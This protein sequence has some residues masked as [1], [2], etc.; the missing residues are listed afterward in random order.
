[1]RSAAHP[2]GDSL[3]QAQLAKLDALIR[4]AG[5]TATDH[6]LEIGCGWGSMAVRAAQTTGCR[7]TGI[8]VSKQQLA[9]ATARVEAAG[10]ADR[11]TLLFCDYRC[12]RWVQYVM[13]CRLIYAMADA[14]WLMLHWQGAQLHTSTAQTTN[15]RLVLFERVCAQEQMLSEYQPVNDSHKAWHPACVQMRRDTPGAGTYD[16]VI[17][18]EMI[19]AVGHEHLAQYFKTINA[20]LKPGGRAAIQVRA[21][22]NAQ[23]SSTG[24]CSYLLTL[25]F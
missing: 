24:R 19:E 2:A 7:W 14:T 8:T 15:Q 17:S 6:V 21:E 25:S 16:K 9:E 3:H 11:V 10:L 5:V 4:T 12:D 13:E 1:M 23:T 22:H 20:M 18:C